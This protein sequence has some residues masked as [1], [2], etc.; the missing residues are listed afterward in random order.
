MRSKSDRTFILPSQTPGAPPELVLP[1]S[2]MAWLLEQP[3]AVLSTSA[4]HYDALH[5]DYSFLTP[6][7]LAD[8]YHEHVIHRSLARNLATLIPAVDAE[9]RNAT[10][11]AFGLDTDEW[12]SVNVWDALLELVPQ[13]TN[14]MLVGPELCRTPSYLA[15]MVGFTND[16]VRNMLMFTFIPAALKPLVGPLLGLPNWLHWK[17][18]ARHTLPLVRRRL[19]DMAAKD[20][21]APGYEDWKEPNDYLSWHIRLARREGRA[22]ELD[23]TRITQRVLPLNFASI[24]TT[25]M[26]AHAVLLDLL[27]A[28]PAAGFV[29]GIRDEAA[30]VYADEGGAWTKDGLARLLRADSAIRESMR[31]S[32]FAQ[33]L[34]GRKVVAPGGLTNAAE[35]WH[36]PPGAKLSLPLW[37]ALHDADLF[38]RP[39]SFDAFRHSREREAWEEAR[40]GTTGGEQRSADDRE[41]GLRLKQKGMVTTGDTHFPWGHGRHACPG[42]F[43]VAHELKMLLAYLF[44]NYDVKPLAERPKTRWIGM[45]IVPAVDARIEVRRKKGTVPVPGA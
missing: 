33:T 15:G 37:G 25:V 2:Q 9:V 5:G 29:D 41:E 26:T 6:A 18:T 23:P 3:D 35:G 7:L 28:D 42:R 31:V 22:D 13:V 10:D 43:F 30:R 34:V 21:G 24:H 17:R 16:V 1:R 20:A 32:A 38:E 45:N 40:R 11:A 4:A 44:L 39:D 8:P 27:A 14:R 12:K 36:A 19:A